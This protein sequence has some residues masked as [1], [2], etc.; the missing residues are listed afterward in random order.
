MKKSAILFVI[1]IMTTVAGYS[2]IRFGIRGGVNISSVSGD[3]IDSF[4]EDNLT[5]FQV[6]PTAEW[7]FNGSFGFE[8]ALLYSEKGIKFKDRSKNKTGYLDLPVGVKWR[9][10]VT[11][12]VKPFIDAGPYISFKISGDDNFDGIKDDVVD[13]WKAKNFAAGLHFGAGVEL[14]K[15][16]QVKVNYGLGLTDNYKA[17]DGEYSVKDRTWSLSTA[18]Y[19]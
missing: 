3:N 16:L 18:I 8:G 6:G 2:Q 14:I 4:I 7:L 11:E 5:G 15:F 10:N 1:F 19:F 13:Q 17:S 12:N 9:F